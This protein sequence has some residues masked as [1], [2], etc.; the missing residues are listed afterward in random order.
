MTSR[1]P[2]QAA[3]NN[4]RQQHD[5]GDHRQAQQQQN[6]QKMPRHQGGQRQP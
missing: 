3:P 1:K 2:S 4:P 5:R 6:Q